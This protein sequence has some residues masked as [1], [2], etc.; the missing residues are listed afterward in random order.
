MEQ[1]RIIF[2][3]SQNLPLE[4]FDF[5]IFWKMSRTHRAWPVASSFFNRC[6]RQLI[7][8]SCA[9][10]EGLTS[11]RRCLSSS[12]LTQLSHQ[13]SM[14]P[15]L[16]L[17]RISPTIISKSHSFSHMTRNCLS[18]LFW[19]TESDIALKCSLWNPLVPPII[20]L[21]IIHSSDRQSTAL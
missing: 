2:V 7:L 8:I 3:A 1:R 20:L 21:V 6:S 16:T 15:S 4:W 5:L 10:R 13:L 17:V 9:L 11:F 19:L 14:L 18:F 12:F